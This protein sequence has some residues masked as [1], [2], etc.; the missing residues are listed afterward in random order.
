MSGANVEDID[1]FRTLRIALIKFRQVAD[2]TL[3]NADAQLSRTLSWLENEQLTYWNNQI[4]KRTEMVSRC[5]E[6]VRTKKLFK[7]ASG[8]TPDASREEKMLK[9]AKQALEEAETRLANTKKSIPK[10]QKEIE[11]YRGGVNGLGTA[12]ASD[13][14]RALAMIE[15]LTLSIEEYVNSTSGVTLE[16]GALPADSSVPTENVEATE[17]APAAEAPKAAE[18]KPQEGSGN[19]TS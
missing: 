4:R 14:P 16:G 13:I 17:A 18:Q 8:R 11:N 12:L 5:V 6:A 15:R 2:T 1:V 9:L 7:D 10:L 19:V 3:L